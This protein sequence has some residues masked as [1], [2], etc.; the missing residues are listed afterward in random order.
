MS[1]AIRPGF[2]KLGMKEKN[3]IKKLNPFKY[4]ILPYFDQECHKYYGKVSH[5]FPMT[6]DFPMQYLMGDAV[7]ELEDPQVISKSV[8][9]EWCQDMFLVTVCI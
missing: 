5:D 6:Y 8:I 7:G 9:G 4:N 2:Y 3:H 1:N